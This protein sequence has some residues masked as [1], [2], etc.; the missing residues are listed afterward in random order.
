MVITCVAALTPT[1]LI[2]K[3][4]WNILQPRIVRM[5]ALKWCEK[6]KVF[7]RSYVSS[8]VLIC[9]ITTFLYSS[10]NNSYSNRR[11]STQL[12]VICPVTIIFIR[13]YKIVSDYRSQRNQPVM[14]AQFNL[15]RNDG[16]AAILCWF[17]VDSN[18]L[19]FPWQAYVSSIV[20]M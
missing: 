16:C 5:N 2:K 19:L 14:Y 9:F 4:T 7:N 1:F 18:F 11:M 20:T 8:C 6:I 17:S 10:T 12:P 3:A 15:R 13:S